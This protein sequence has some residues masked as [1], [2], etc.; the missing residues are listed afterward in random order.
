MHHN[1]VETISDNVTRQRLSN[2]LDEILAI[3]APDEKAQALLAFQTE[4][5]NNPLATNALA[6]VDSEL[7]LLADAADEARY[8]A[9]R[10]EPNIELRRQL[11]VNYLDTSEHQKRKE[12]AQDLIAGI[13]LQL[14][15]TAWETVEAQRLDLPAYLAALESY[16]NGTTIRRRETQAQQAIKQTRIQIAEQTAIREDRAAWDAVIT[17]ESN[18]RAQMAAAMAYLADRPNGNHASAAQDL[19]ERI[20][21]HIDDTAWA[22]AISTEGNSQQ[23]QIA[24][25]KAYLQADTIQG[26]ANEAQAR[27]NA[28]FEDI[29]SAAWRSIRDSEGSPQE[30]IALA[31]DY[32]AGDTLKRHSNEA[33]QLIDVEL[34]REDFNAW[35]AAQSVADYSARIH[36]IEHYLAGSTRLEYKKNAEAEIRKVL[37]ILN[38]SED[39][40]LRLADPD[41]L[42]RLNPATLRRVN[43]QVLQRLESLPIKR[44]EALDPSVL[45]RFPPTLAAKLSLPVRGRLER[46]PAWAE[47]HG[48]DEWSPG[49]ASQSLT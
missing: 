47:S 41:I 19:L 3:E 16:V 6:K 49:Q 15:E 23:Q 10:D 2:R 20:P 28:L 27:I 45:I 25:L 36:A 13:D 21:R 43:V 7:R 8:R 9:A 33:Q 40:V 5:Q 42:A 39:D 4:H 30:R 18:P 46:R 48:V 34:A 22:K 24:L 29:D 1:K 11:L 38:R 44:L 32:L 14:D 35:I 26:H 17:L 37:D 12:F 31:R